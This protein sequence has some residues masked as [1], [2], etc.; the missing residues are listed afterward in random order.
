MSSRYT[1]IA[2]SPFFGGPG[3]IAHR[4]VLL[5]WEGQFSVHTQALSDEALLSGDYT[6]EYQ[7]ALEWWL[8][9]TEEKYKSGEPLVMLRARGTYHDPLRK[10]GDGS[11]TTAGNSE[12]I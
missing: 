6:K 12:G 4:V 8:D 2:A 11:Y 10:L 1:V 3:T 7:K 5:E 9:R